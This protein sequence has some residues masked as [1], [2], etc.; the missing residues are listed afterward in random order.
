MN[1]GA[2]AA[3]YAELPLPST[4]EESWR[5]T[6]LK[7]FDPDAFSANG[8]KTL[9]QTVARKSMLDIDVAGLA[10]VDSGGIAIIGLGITAAVVGSPLLAGFAVGLGIGLLIGN[11]V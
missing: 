2:A 6:D 10:T 4:T 3:R 5:F 8:T 9:Q 11:V 7:G 1:R